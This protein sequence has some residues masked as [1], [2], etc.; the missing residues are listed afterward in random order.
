MGGVFDP[1]I[2]QQALT[3]LPASSNLYETGSP[4]AGYRPSD[5]EEDF[6]T[7]AEALAAP[8]YDEIMNIYTHRLFRQNS[9]LSTF[10]RLAEVMERW[11]NQD[12]ASVRH[13]AVTL[14]MDLLGEFEE[15]NVI[16]D[17]LS[18]R[19]QRSLQYV[20]TTSGIVCHAGVPV[21]IL[22]CTYSEYEL[23]KTKPGKFVFQPQRGGSSVKQNMSGMP[24]FTR[25]RLFALAASTYKPDKA[26]FVSFDARFEGP[27]LTFNAGRFSKDFVLGNWTDGT[28]PPSLYYMEMVDIRSQDGRREMAR[29]LVAFKRYLKA[30]AE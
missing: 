21:L 9:F 23:V 13:F 27:F 20:V 15:A 2:L 17:D 5:G 4:L 29:V 24:A 1:Q 12:E 30:R 19:V 10:K 25:V 22:D 8:T 11:R 26:S 18:F 16:P 7:V 3:G 28:P 14:F 6:E